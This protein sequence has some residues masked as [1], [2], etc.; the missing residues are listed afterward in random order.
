MHGAWEAAVE[1]E[2]GSLDCVFAERAVGHGWFGEDGLVVYPRRRVGCC[3]GEKG[4]G[5]WE[6]DLGVV[7]LVVVGWWWR[8]VGVFANGRWHSG[9]HDGRDH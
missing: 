9:S 7:V 8:W 6:L 1:A 5:G 4:G 3:A 2:R